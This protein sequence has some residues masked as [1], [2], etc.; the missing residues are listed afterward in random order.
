MAD[1][2]DA[3]D[4]H[5]EAAWKMLCDGFRLENVELT[6]TTPRA[7]F[8]AGWDAAMAEAAKAIQ[9]GRDARK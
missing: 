1:K 4:A 6:D 2:M 8:M 3:M 9:A 7:M 5:R